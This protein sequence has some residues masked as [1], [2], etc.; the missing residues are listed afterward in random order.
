MSRSFDVS[1]GKRKEW[2]TSYVVQ[3]VGTKTQKSETKGK[4]YG[5]EFGLHG[6]HGR[7][8]TSQQGRRG[9]LLNR[10]QTTEFAVEEAVEMKLTFQ[11]KWRALR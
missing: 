4:K 2:E 6:I 5:G 10:K 3:N 9:R 1:L 11:R 7:W 8:F